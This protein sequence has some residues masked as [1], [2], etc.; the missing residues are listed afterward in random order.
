MTNARRWMIVLA[1]GV[2]SVVVVGAAPRTLSD[3]FTAAERD[4]TDAIARY[5]DERVVQTTHQLRAVLREN[6]AFAR[7]HIELA[8]ALLWLDDLDG[9]AQSLSEARVL[10]FRNAELSLL[11][12]R[13]AV[14]RGDF[15]AARLRYNELLAREPYHRRGRIEAAVLELSE[16]F[17]PAVMDQ[18]RALLRRYP[19]DR[20]LAITFVEIARLME[21]WTEYDRAIARALRFHGDSATVQLVAAEGALREGSHERALRYA[22]RATEIAP[23][24]AQAW[25][26]VGEVSLGTSRWAAARTA[27]DRYLILKP[28]DERAWYTRGYLQRQEG[29]IAGALDS[30]RRAGAIQ[31]DFELARL[32]QEALVMDE[33]PI[34]DPSRATAGEY[35]RMVAGNLQA[36]Y[37]SRQAEFA[38]RRGLM[39]NP[40]DPVLRA[41]RVELFTQRGYIGRSLDE[42]SFMEENH[43]TAEGEGAYSAARVEDLIET[44]EA[45]RREAP[46]VRWG[47]DQFGEQRPR[48]PIAIIGRGGTGGLPEEETIVA[49]YVA[50]LVRGEPHIEVRPTPEADSRTELLARGAAEGIAY[51]VELTPRLSSGSAD[52]S[53]V[54]YDTA[55]A[56]EQLS[57]RLRRSGNGRLET[58]LREAYTRIAHFLPLR[59]AVVARRFD[60]VLVSL[61]RI[62]GVEQGDEL[63]FLPEHAADQRTEPITATVTAVDDSVSEVLY[64]G[65]RPDYLSVGDL[66]E[67]A[68]PPPLEVA[69]GE[70]LPPV[71]LPLPRVGPIDYRAVTRR[72]FQVR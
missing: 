6:P 38:V 26:M 9:A 54:I 49:A 68:S 3:R 62:D 36:R 7:A 70:T 2:L 18:L 60:T 64:Q 58:V 23:H 14:L 45:R 32:A 27:Y 40:L 39:I 31:P 69:D 10:A 11:E 19:D 50:G 17:A 28:D 52:L 22:T 53:L 15:D 41:M 46:A 21:D 13:L 66:V 51:V 1:V 29:D 33:T 47:V 25:A 37:F 65:G 57:L 71:S 12:G 30:W 61:G 55:T 20:L 5:D 56:G 4:L 67:I 35:Y 34:G 42:L 43:L 48:T 16:G 8:R 63:L 44:Y 72:L 59:G 24:Y